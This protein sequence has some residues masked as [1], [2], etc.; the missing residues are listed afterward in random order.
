MPAADPQV[1]IATLEAA[2]RIASRELHWTNLTIQKR[3]AEIELLQE[4]L[5]KQRIGFLGPSSETLS[6]LQLELLAEEEPG[7]TR[8]EVE[9]ESRREPIP[10]APSRKRRPHPGRKPLPQQLPRVEE[11]IPCEANCSNC[12][13]ETRV[14][15]YD[16][17]EVLDREPAKWFVRVTKREKRSCGKCSAIQ[18][19]PLSPRIVEKGLASD[20][21][22]IETVVA[23]YADHLPLYRQE[24]ILQRE[25]GV[26]I[27][28]ATLDG[29]V[30]RVGELAQALVDAMRAGLLSGSYLQ[31]DETI[32]PVQMR[33][34]SG[35]DHPAYLWQYGTPG[36]ETVFDFQLGRGREGP[37]KF[38]KDWNGIL[39]TDGYQAYDQVGGPGL[40]HVGCWA[41]YPDTGI[42]PRLGFEGPFTAGL[43]AMSS[44]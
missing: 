15:G 21:V 30:M 8:E 16:S 29:W 27:S 37:A 44:G 34:G 18:M 19:P 42:I 7:V 25:A 31:A 40:I 43:T 23:K 10:A 41:H 24:A 17:S 39:Q 28:R 22:V 1:R 20:R 4:R 11:V 36:G 38:L 6:D 26:E 5:R 33:D 14:I 32:V 9:A 2:L 35:S 12:G 3:D 13:G